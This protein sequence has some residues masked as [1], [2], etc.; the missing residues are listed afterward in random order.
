M[1][2]ENAATAARSSTDWYPSS[3]LDRAKMNRWSEEAAQEIANSVTWTENGAFLDILRAAAVIRAAHAMEFGGEWEYC[4]PCDAAE[5]W[6]GSEWEPI[7]M[8]SVG[9]FERQV[10]SRNHRRRVRVDG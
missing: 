7:G 9:K 2:S 5:Y 10:I 4:K 1:S 8:A 3:P 6:N